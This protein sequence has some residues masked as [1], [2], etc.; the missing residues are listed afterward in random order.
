MNIYKRYTAE[1]NIDPESECLARFVFGG[2][3]EYVPH[4]HD[5]YEVFIVAKGTVGHAVNGI[6][7][8][9]PAGSLVFIRPDDIHGH[10]CNDKNSAFINLTFTKETAKTLLTYLFDSDYI[11][12]LLSCDIPPM[13]FLDKNS[14]ET[15]I[16]QINALNTERWQ[17][18]NAL[19]IRARIILVNIF[20]H[21]A[22]S[23]PESKNNSIPFWLIEL[24]A[25]MEKPENFTCGTERM[26]KL[27]RKSREH[28]ARCFKKY[29]NQTVTDYVNGLRINYA[30]NL[31]I[32][33]NMPIIDVCFEC[34]F[35]S[36]S[37]FYRTFKEKN[38]LTPSELRS[39]YN[40][41]SNNEQNVHR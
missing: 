34:G 7:Q 13:V 33:T 24:T 14:R 22:S 2:D 1:N 16:S 31:L 37:Y 38:N 28:V 5:Y 39:K 18:K 11:E 19:K 6:M 36:L 8:N 21:F 25:E 3:D 15:L 41:N 27:C 40:Y 9:L 29:F 12:N 23:L 20:S 30:S 17:D 35:Q 32:N 26:T 4:S 10:L